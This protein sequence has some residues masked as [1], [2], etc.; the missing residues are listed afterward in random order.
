MY[1][2]MTYARK[3]RP[4]VPAVMT[5]FSS[6]AKE[7]G[8]VSWNQMEF[9]VAHPLSN[10]EADIVLEK[11]QEIKDAISQEKAFYSNQQA[12]P[13]GNAELEGEFHKK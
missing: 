7:N 12:R 8:S 9:V 4:A 1:S 10:K 2:Y 11:Q 6:E 3:V 5:H 13:V